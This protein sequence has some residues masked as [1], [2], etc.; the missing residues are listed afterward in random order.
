MSGA[1]DP[2]AG[3]GAAPSLPTP[4]PAAPAAPGGAVPW[5]PVG[6]ADPE[7]EAGRFADAEATPMHGLDAP[8]GAL[9][10]IE[11][12]AF[13]S[14]IARYVG[15]Q[16][17]DGGW[18]S[19]GKAA[20]PT[21]L[22]VG[23]GGAGAV[24][25]STALVPPDE[26][27][28]EG[29]AAGLTPFSNPVPRMVLNS[30]LGAAENAQK[31]AQIAAQI[32]AGFP[33]ALHATAAFAAQMLDPVYLAATFIPIGGEALLGAGLARAGLED[34]AGTALGRVATRAAVG[35]VTGAA[36]QVPLTG[37]QALLSSQEHQDFTMADALNQVLAGAAFGAVLHPVAG[38]IGD[39]WSAFRGSPAGRVVAGDPAIRRD[40][41]QAALA[42]VLEDRPVQVHAF[43]ELSARDREQALALRSMQYDATQPVGMRLNALEDDMT[44]PGV[45]DTLAQNLAGQHA[46]L[47]DI[48]ASQQDMGTI[49]AQ[50]F[51]P[52]TADRLHAIEDELTQPGPLGA[53]RQ[54]GL[55]AEH[56]M[57]TEGGAPV[58]EGLAAARDE[59]QRQ[60]NQIAIDRNESR[61]AALQDQI[62]SS[63]TVQQALGAPPPEAAAVSRTADILAAQHKPAPAIPEAPAD[64]PDI[65]RMVEGLRARG[66]LGS[67]G[68]TMM[69]QIDAAGQEHEQFAK[70]VESLGECMGSAA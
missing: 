29:K 70:A 9:S 8:A 26:A 32:P 63:A 19:L 7:D 35:A 15:R 44:R 55:L 42:A 14:E 1:L 39:A 13:T 36:A 23:A 25:D 69:K 2:G 30:M 53:K 10:G 61:I 20:A 5:Q 52:A 40:T 31:R 58:D 21:L 12:P 54:A 41:G 49:G 66:Q 45:P 28:A 65:E 34:A 59:A 37:V 62:R 4:A 57:L 47:T 50:S 27:N 68:E 48:A 67:E 43:I 33:S 64:L 16:A 56:R 17:V 60:G 3:V 46:A 11:W 51:D 38:A 18:G 22:G 6:L 24:G